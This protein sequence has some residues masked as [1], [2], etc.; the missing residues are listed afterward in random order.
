MLHSIIIIFWGD[1][2]TATHHPQNIVM[3]Q[4]FNNFEAVDFIIFNNF[5]KNC[6]V[7]AEAC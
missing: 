3:P 1:V 5:V 7:A 2:C 6:N 4:R